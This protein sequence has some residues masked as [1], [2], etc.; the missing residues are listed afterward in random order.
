MANKDQSIFDT[1]PPV[2]PRH[3]WRRLQASSPTTCNLPT[4]KLSCSAFS[5]PPLHQRKVTRA[6]CRSKCAC[7]PLCTPGCCCSPRRQWLG[8]TLRRSW[9]GAE[10]EG[11]LEP[12]KQ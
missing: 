9:H 7:G 2:L 8:N 12:A 1:T 6:L 3:H 10:G 5:I 11:S 4:E